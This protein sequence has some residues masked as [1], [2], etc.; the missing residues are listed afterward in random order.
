MN[1]ILKRENN[2]TNIIDC[3]EIDK[4][5][6]FNAQE[7]ANE[8]GKHFSSIGKLYANKTKPP[9]KSIDHYNSKIEQ[10]TNSMFLNPTNCYEIRKVIDNLK[11]KHSSGHDNVSNYLIKKL[12][13]VMITPLC[14]VI[15]KSLQEG[16]FP[17]RMKNAEV[18]P[19][20]KGKDRINKN[21]YRPI[22]LLLTLSKILE[23][24]IYS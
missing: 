3:L 6:T 23:K 19:L 17:T 20:Y 12:K 4:I 13:D 8:F 14:I 21:N 11:N 2:K 22:S 10:N 5:K 16:F 9:A 7:I 24:V 18:V 15:N 1:K